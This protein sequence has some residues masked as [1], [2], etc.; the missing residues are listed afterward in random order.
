MW[1]L[2]S[3]WF[4]SP[5]LCIFNSHTECVLKENI[6]LLIITLFPLFQS[7]LHL[8]L[9]HMCTFFSRKHYFKRTLITSQGL[10]F[11]QTVYCFLMLSFMYLCIYVSLYLRKVPSENH[12]LSPCPVSQNPDDWE[13]LPLVNGR[14]QDQK[15][16]AFLDPID[17]LF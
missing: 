1:E 3:H 5:L 7:L 13:V 15:Y 16:W 9:Q 8:S 12:H 2:S 17:V 11:R 14:N 4:S 10:S 6:Y